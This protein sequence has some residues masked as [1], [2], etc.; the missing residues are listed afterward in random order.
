MEEIWK[1]IEGFEGLY[2][3]S[4]LGLVKRLVSIKCKKERILKQSK[5]LNGYYFVQLCKNG[6]S[7]YAS[8]ARTVAKAFCDPKEGCNEVNH[9]NERKEINCA[10]NL[11]WCDRKYNCNYGNRNKN[12][13]RPILQYALNGAFIKEWKSACQAQRETG[14]DQGSITRCCQHKRIQARGYKW[15][16]K[17]SNA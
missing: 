1:D 13:S 17:D 3:V 7:T 12:I 6:K 9:I 16:Y 15:E 5:H 2:Q 4:N 8:I 10:T 11:E 14:I